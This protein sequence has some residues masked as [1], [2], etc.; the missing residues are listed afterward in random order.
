M[1][2]F[3]EEIFH[4]AKPTEFSLKG[5]WRTATSCPPLLQPL[6]S[7]VQ[8]V[9]RKRHIS[10]KYRRLGTVGIFTYYENNLGRIL[11]NITSHGHIKWNR[12]HHG[13]NDRSRYSANINLLVD[14]KTYLPP[15]CL[16]IQ[17]SHLGPQGI[18]MGRKIWLICQCYGDW[19]CGVPLNS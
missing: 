6:Y 17:L 4:F 12:C 2:F 15:L 3:F 9:L 19:R 13:E 5:G 7:R 10:F 11:N 1:G 14:L 18:I 16:W 8:W